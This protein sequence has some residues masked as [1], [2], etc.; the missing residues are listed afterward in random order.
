[1]ITRERSKKIIT[2]SIIGFFVLLVLGYA[3]FAFRDISKGPEITI[4]EPMNGETYATSTVTLKGIALRAQELTF[5][6]KPLLIDENNTFN[7]QIVLYD[8]Y[9]NITIEAK[10]RFGHATV[11]KLQLM[12]K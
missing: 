8:G 1:M 11:T 5:N 4:L 6:G 7:E 2:W 10:D 9:N 12:K 3:F